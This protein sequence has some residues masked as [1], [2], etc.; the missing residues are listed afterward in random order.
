MK[1]YTLKLEKKSYQLQ[2]VYIEHDEEPSE[3]HKENT[4][5]DMLSNLSKYYVTP[6]PAD[7]EK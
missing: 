2:L 6:F 1:S 5:I 4:N 7:V 3:A